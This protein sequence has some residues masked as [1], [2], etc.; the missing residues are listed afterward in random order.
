MLSLPPDLGVLT[1]SSRAWEA[2]ER[3]KY[4]GYDAILPFRTAVERRHMPYS[5]NWR[6]VSAM[7][8]VLESINVEESY[9]RH[10]AVARMTRERITKMG[11]DLFTP[12]SLAAPTVTAVKVPGTWTWPE[13]DSALRKKQVVFGG[14]Y[15]SLKNVVFRIGHMGSQANVEMVSGALDCLESVLKEHK[16]Q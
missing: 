3:V 5:H 11:L 10:E 15:G 16:E 1:I 4:R 12:E 14:S 7:R 9:A 13:L 2:A 8:H 6:A